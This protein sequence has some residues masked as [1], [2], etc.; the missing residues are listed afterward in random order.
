MSKKRLVFSVAKVEKLSTEQLRSQYCKRIARIPKLRSVVRQFMGKY[1]W[2][3]KSEI[4]IIEDSKRLIENVDWRT[5]E[6]DEQ[7]SDFCKMVTENFNLPNAPQWR[8][9]V[10][11]D[12]SFTQSAYLIACHGALNEELRRIFK[13]AVVFNPSQHLYPIKPKELWPQQRPEYVEN[14]R[15]QNEKR[16][17][18]A[19]Y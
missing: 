14:L 5:V 12:Y 6:S 17:S 7:L 16:H 1:I 3:P 4:E 2:Q 13:R 9:F 18:V 10:F 11:E 15:P 19:H 8:I